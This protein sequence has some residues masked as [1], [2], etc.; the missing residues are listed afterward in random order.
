MVVLPQVAV[1][2]K[3]ALSRRWISGGGHRVRPHGS[4]RLGGPRLVHVGIVDGRPFAGRAVAAAT[5][6]LR[7]RRATGRVGPEPARRRR[8]LGPSSPATRTRLDSVTRKIRLRWSRSTRAVHVPPSLETRRRVN[9]HPFGALSLSAPPTHT[10]HTPPALR[11]LL[12]SPFPRPPPSPPSLS[13]S[14]ALSPSLPLYQSIS[15]QWPSQ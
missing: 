10:P 14:P 13:H 8:R 9:P 6:T 5:R 7:R 15:Q 1:D 11:I 12:T 2:D 3:R 4:A